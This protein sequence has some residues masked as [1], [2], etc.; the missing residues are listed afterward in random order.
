MA[1]NGNNMTTEP[2]WS[3]EGSGE[4]QAVR[5]IVTR[6]RNIGGQQTA[7]AV[8]CPVCRGRKVL[9]KGSAAR[10]NKRMGA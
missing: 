8:K 7:K 5:T 6:R 2:C 1:G 4:V 9:R 3:C 10:M